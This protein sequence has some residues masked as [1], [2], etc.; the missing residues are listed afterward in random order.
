[1]T[2]TSSTLKNRTLESGAE[3]SR[4]EP[5][6]GEEADGRGEGT[7]RPGKDAVVL[8]N[9]TAGGVRWDAAAVRD[10]LAPLGEV[11]VIVTNGSGHARREA[12]RA[13]RGGIEMV[14]A[15]GGD[16]T[17]NSVVNGIAAG[18]GTSC[19]GVFPL[20]T[21]NDFAHSLGLPV[22]PASAAETIVSGARRRIDLASVEA[23]S[24][25]LF[26]NVAAGGLGLSDDQDDDVK[27]RLG[28]LAYLLDAAGEMSGKTP[29][30]IHMEW[31]E[32]RVDADVLAVIVANGSSSGGNVPV[33]PYALPDD[34]LLDVVLIPALEVGRLTALAARIL[35]GQHIGD[36]DVVVRRTREVRIRSQ[37]ALRFRLDGEDV[38][39]GYFRA[40]CLPAALE[41]TVPP[42][43]PRQ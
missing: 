35:V 41:V 6:R 31:D 2:T 10:V 29:H 39:E 14:V 9:P 25:K 21:A 19:L 36:D 23:P 16:G 27:T 11:E 5:S 32:G 20:G 18:G 37:P 26:V 33:A 24:R 30:R 13:T 42:P 7:S 22:D 1:M 43:P 17:I 8:L 15:G 38:G 40:E 28:R 3:R 4:T 34:G 12:E